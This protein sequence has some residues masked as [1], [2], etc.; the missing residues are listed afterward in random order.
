MKIEYYDEHNEKLDFLNFAL[1]G[2]S[3]LRISDRAKSWKINFRILIPCQ[4]LP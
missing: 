2:F 3:L 1:D 4:F